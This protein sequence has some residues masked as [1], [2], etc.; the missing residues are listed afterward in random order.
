[1]E[2]VANMRDRCVHVL[3]GK[4]VAK[5]LLVRPRRKLEHNN[6]MVLQG[7]GWGRGLKFSASGQRLVVCFCER[8]NGSSGSIK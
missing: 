7:V 3:V 5:R 8:Y 6:K 4:L 1:M 2:H